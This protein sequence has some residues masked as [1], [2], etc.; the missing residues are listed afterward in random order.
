MSQLCSS[1]VNI[2]S[3]CAIGFLRQNHMEKYKTN[4]S[5]SADNSKPMQF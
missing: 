2:V 3:N 1:L 5:F 4:S